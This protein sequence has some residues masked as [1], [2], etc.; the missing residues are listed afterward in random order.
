MIQSGD[1]ARFAIEP[2]ETL[3]VLRDVRWQHFERDVAPESRIPRA[4]YVAHSTRTERGHNF[5][6]TKL[7]TNGKRHALQGIM[8]RGRSLQR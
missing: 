7:V 5:V 6:R 2:F 3:G 8:D 4:I 1:G